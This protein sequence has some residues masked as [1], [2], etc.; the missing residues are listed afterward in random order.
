MTPHSVITRRRRLPP[1]ARPAR[2]SPSPRR[3][4]SSSSLPTALWPHTRAAAAQS[5]AAQGAATELRRCGSPCTAP[6]GKTY[7]SGWVGFGQPPRRGRRTAASASAA[8]SA[9]P[10]PSRMVQ[11]LRPGTVTL[12]A[13]PTSVV[14]TASF[15]QPGDS[16][17]RDEG[18][19]RASSRLT[20]TR[21]RPPRA[22]T[23]RHAPPH[24]GRRFWARRSS[25]R[26]M[27]APIS[28]LTTDIP[29]AAT[30]ASTTSSKPA[31]GCAANR[32]RRTG[33]RL[34]RL[35]TRDGRC[36]ALMVDPQGDREVETAQAEDACASSTTGIPKIGAQH[37]DGYQT[38][39]TL[40]DI[41]SLRRTPAAGDRGT[42]RDAAARSNHEGYVAGYFIELGHQ[43]HATEHRPPAK[44]TRRRSSPTTAIAAPKQEWFDATRR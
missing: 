12:A 34:Q 28:E 31:R 43:P 22:R 33:L 14:T 13:D 30:A 24:G 20:V 29:P 27:S 3:L 17:A 26:R 21:R 11:S 36:L 18:P 38:A 7:L 15:S 19:R 23:R 9:T 37:P 25:R 41:V 44:T 32:T 5:G 10:P 35:V 1:P 40:R 8:L 4:S 6:P 2:P 42:D 16:R 39:F